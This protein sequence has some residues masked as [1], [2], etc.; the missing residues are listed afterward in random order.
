MHNFRFEAT[1]EKVFGLSRTKLSKV[2][3]RMDLK[4]VGS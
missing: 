1:W 4:A 2:N 3:I